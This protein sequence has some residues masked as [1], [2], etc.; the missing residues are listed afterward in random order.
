[1]ALLDRLKGLFGATRG[2]APRPAADAA[3]P[4]AP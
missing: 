2:T 1:M 3:I 4:R